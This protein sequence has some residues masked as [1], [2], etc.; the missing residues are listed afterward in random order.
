MAARVLWIVLGI[1]SLSVQ[2]HEGP[3]YPLAK[4]IRSEYGNLSLWTDPDVGNGTF[5]FV[6]EEEPSGVPQLSVSASSL[7]VP[8]QDYE[9]Q[10]DPQ[11]HRQYVVTI[12][13]AHEGIWNL[14]FRIGASAPLAF[15]VEVT[16]PGPVSWQIW[17]F[18]FPFALVGLL[19]GKL[20]W[21]RWR[22]S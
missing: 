19:W 7:T 17:I 10:P 1:L 9:A 4:E 11:N 6:F 2:A 5:I 3:P 21:S 13:F 12:P 22:V 15:P 18:L 16:P 8:R 20:F 14:E